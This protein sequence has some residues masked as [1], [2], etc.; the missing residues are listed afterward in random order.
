MHE[1]AVESAFAGSDKLFSWSEW[2]VDV[3]GGE[4]EEEWLRCLTSFNPFD[5]FVFQRRPDQFIDIELVSF[6][7]SANIS[8]TL[9]RVFFGNRLLAVDDWIGWIGSEDVVVF[10]VDKWWTAIDA[11]NSEIVIKAQLKWSW[12]KLPIPIGLLMTKS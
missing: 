3:G 5:S 1:V 12:F 11:W 10:H 9:F 4:V 7:S 2:V 8:G 6:L